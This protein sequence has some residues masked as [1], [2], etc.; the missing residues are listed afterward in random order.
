MKYVV[1]ID[2]VGRGS[3]AGPVAIAV[4]A[5]PRGFKINNKKLGPLKDSKRLTPKKREGWLEYVAENKN[6]SYKLA[7]IYPKTI[8]RI[9]I[10]RSAN[11]AAR[12]AFLRLADEHH[13]KKNNCQIYLDGGLFLGNKGNPKNAKTVVRGDKKYLS[14]KL[15]SIIAKVNRDRLMSRLSKKYPDY[16]F[17]IHKGYGTKAHFAVIKKLGPSE[18]HRLTFIGK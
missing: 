3:L 1:G 14:I 2:E 11:L 13:L 6:I 12:R 15:A 17:D 8:D 9:N 16:S 10:S 7:K 18:I 5:V 4:V